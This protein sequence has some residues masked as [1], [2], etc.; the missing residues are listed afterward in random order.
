MP[1]KKSRVDEAPSKQLAVCVCI[2]I[3]ASLY[4]KCLVGRPLDMVICAA[5]STDVESL[6]ETCTKIK[7][8]N[9]TF[10]TSDIF[11]LQQESDEKKC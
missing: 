9:V 1:D 7:G 2:F 10:K 4:H 6:K 11:F 8:N 5:R 3:L